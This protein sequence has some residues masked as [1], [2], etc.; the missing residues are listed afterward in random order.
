MVKSYCF[1]FY[2]LNTFRLIPC[3]SFCSRVLKIL[4]RPMCTRLNSDLW[5]SIEVGRIFSWKQPEKVWLLM[6]VIDRNIRIILSY[7]SLCFWTTLRE[8]DSPPCTT[9]AVTCVNI[10]LKSWV[11]WLWTENSKSI[12]QNEPFSLINVFISVICWE[13]GPTYTFSNKEQYLI[14]C[15]L[16]QWK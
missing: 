8:A 2:F 12:R 15:P 9:T 10:D 11:K 5:H 6:C 3:G 7:L 4:Q 16:N 1:F 14:E 13:R